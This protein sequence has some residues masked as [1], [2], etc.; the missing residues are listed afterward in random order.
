MALLS[1]SSRNFARSRLHHPYLTASVIIIYIQRCLRNTSR[2]NCLHAH[3]VYSSARN[4]HSRVHS[5]RM[6]RVHWAP[7][8]RA[9][10]TWACAFFHCARARDV[11]DVVKAGDELRSLRNRGDSLFNKRFGTFDCGL[12]A[13]RV[14]VGWGEWLGGGGG[15]GGGRQ[16][17]T[18]RQTQTDTDSQRQI[19]RETDRQ[20]QTMR[21]RERVREEY[22]SWLAFD[23][24]L[25]LWRTG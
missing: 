1:V 25:L 20:R 8:T 18:E 15:V 3:I 2:S 13:I 19:D 16:R 12:S 11:C 17:Q 4:E 6:T 14:G 24:T 21:K 23:Y 10:V 9:E 7:P 22:I 5:P